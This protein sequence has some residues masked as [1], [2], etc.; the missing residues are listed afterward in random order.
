M[1]GPAVE[2]YD[3]SPNGK[4]DGSKE[5]EKERIKSWFCSSCS[6]PP[7]FNE[8]RLNLL[9]LVTFLL[10]SVFPSYSKH[11]IAVYWANRATALDGP[12]SH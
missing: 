5:E 12:G 6:A 11:I 7:L 4:C 3:V 2:G 10:H 1:S 9:T 8:S